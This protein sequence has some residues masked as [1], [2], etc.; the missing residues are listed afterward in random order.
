MNVGGKGNGGNFGSPGNFTDQVS[1]GRVN[2]QR[3][4]PAG[5][6]GN[7]RSTE[8]ASWTAGLGASGGGGNPMGHHSAIMAA[9]GFPEGPV[10]EEFVRQRAAEVRRAFKDVDLE[11]VIVA[12][13][14][15]Q[16][17]ELETHLRASPVTEIGRYRKFP[18]IGL[19]G[20]RHVCTFDDICVVAFK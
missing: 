9:L 15:E 19:I 6:G 4:G 11:F 20:S 14:E 2:P 18:T 5:L 16:A 10:D 12:L 13:T 3:V 1:V 17:R 7:E 8:A